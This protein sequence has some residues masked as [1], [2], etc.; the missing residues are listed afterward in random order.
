MTIH[1]KEQDFF[2]EIRRSIKISY[3]VASIIPLAILVYFFVI[4]I[5]PYVQG[6]E[7]NAASSIIVILLLSVVLSLL[8]LTMS[9]KTTNRSLSSVQEVHGK[10]N[11]L[12]EV[13]KHF[14]D[15]LF[16]DV[17]LETIVQSATEL[18]D[19]ETGSLLLTDDKGELGY[20]LALGET[21]K[22]IKVKSIKPGEGIAGWVFQNGSSAIVND[23][24]KDERHRPQFEP[25]G[26][27][28]TTSVLCV[29]LI[30]DKKTI[31][32]LE[33][34]NK[35]SGDFT[36]RDEKL[37]FSLA[38]Q[39]AISI[40]QSKVRDSQHTDTIQMTEIL[41]N[42]MDHHSPE[43]KGH[44]KRVAMY[45]S[46]IGKRYNFSDDELRKLYF[47]GVLHD[48]GFLRYEYFENWDER[49]K[50]HPT[51][52]YE[53]VRPISLWGDIAHL[54]LYHHERYDGTGYPKGKMGTEIPLGARIIAVADT[55]DTL[56]SEHSYKEKISESEALEELERHAGT[57]FDPAVV[58][59][60]KETLRSEGIPV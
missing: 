50:E 2:E 27:F 56:T 22:K 49:I 18:L 24:R 46:N 40:A 20:K 52:G 30:Y 29:P 60:L 47:A 23:I 32:V 53:M 57:Q 34:F 31:G 3:F 55:F 58:D 14:R 45:A 37:L 28:K 41:V 21:E 13:T 5:Y 15:T 12:L 33:I 9:V 16:V 38:D 11:A 43:R 39:A 7:T 1:H 4:Y 42:T 51:I 6:A 10:L 19:A 36:E 26:S 54:I 17:L 8:G 44:A 48:V 35:R 59:A 25:G